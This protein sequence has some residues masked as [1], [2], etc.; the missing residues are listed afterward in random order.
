MPRSKRPSATYRGI[1]C[2]R[3]MRT[4]SMRGSAI[5]ALYSTLGERLTVR[6]AD[7]NRLM[8]ARSSEPLGRTSFN[9]PRR[10]RTT[11]PTPGI[12]SAGAPSRGGRAGASGR[13]EPPAQQRHLDRHRGGLLAHVVAPGALRAGERLALVLGGEHAE[14]HGHTGR[15]L[16]LLHAVGALAGDDVVVGGL[17]PDHRADA[18]DGVDAARGRQRPGTEGDLEGARH[19]DLDDVA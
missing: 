6:P 16:D 2:G 9:T 3:R 12:D 8:V 5:E 4:S 17:A 14:R 10:V 19:L 11:G 13:A 7:P 1:S 18:D 15:E